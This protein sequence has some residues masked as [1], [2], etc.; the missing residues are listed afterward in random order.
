LDGLSHQWRH[1]LESA[2]KGAWADAIVRRLAHSRIVVK[3]RWGALRA[4]VRHGDVLRAGALRP[5]AGSNQGLAT[6]VVC[7]LTMRSSSHSSQ[8]RRQSGGCAGADEFGPGARDFAHQDRK[9]RNVI[10]P[11]DG[12]QNWINATERA[13]TER[14]DDPRDPDS[15]PADRRVR[16]WSM[17]WTRFGHRALY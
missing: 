10:V 16:R 6:S 5:T 1:Q 14:P 8:I 3:N 4:T 13:S 7:T 9:W 2:T 15:T 11:F 12:R 17:A